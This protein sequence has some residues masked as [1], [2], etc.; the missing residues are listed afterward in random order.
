MKPS[1][2]KD[3]YAGLTPPKSLNTSTLDKIDDLRS[4]NAGRK[5]LSVPLPAFALAACLLAIALCV[6]SQPNEKGGGTGLANTFNLEI[7]EAD[8]NTGSAEVASSQSGLLPLQDSIGPSL[9]LLLNLDVTGANVSSVTYRMVDGASRS[10]R[11]TGEQRGEEAPVQTHD[12]VRLLASSATSVSDEDDVLDETFTVAY[13]EGSGT[14]I[15]QTADGLYPYLF[16]D[17]ASENYWNSDPTLALL[18]EWVVAGTGFDEFDTNPTSTTNSTE[19]NPGEADDDF[20][21]RQQQRLSQMIAA[22]EQ[23]RQAYL[24]AFDQ[25]ASD[26][27]QF[28]SWLKDL[29]IRGYEAAGERLSSARLE[30]TVTFADGSTQTRLYRISLV[31]NYRD[32]LQGRFDALCA[33][34]DN[35]SQQLENKL[36]WTA[37]ETPTSEQVAAD[38]RLSAAIFKIEETDD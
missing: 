32:A 16:V 17:S 12:T 5:P 1:D 37:W 38:E 22:S 11:V 2:L 35:F 27:D 14:G 20:R 18:H 3:L 30:A 31:E 29:Y 21:A 23:A 6:T 7:A 24:E 19:Q 34:D 4:A 25:Q 26:A 10:R 28:A 13:K 15:Y 33:L 36:P 8:D 9:K